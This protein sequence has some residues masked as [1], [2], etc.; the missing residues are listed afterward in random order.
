MVARRLRS[1]ATCSGFPRRTFMIAR[2]KSAAGCL[3]S[4]LR[5]APNSR[6]ASSMFPVSARATA[7]SDRS[8]WSVETLDLD[9]LTAVDLNLTTAAD[10][11]THGSMQMQDA[12]ADL[13]LHDGRLTYTLK[14]IGIDKGRATG[15]MDVDASAKPAKSARVWIFTAPRCWQILPGSAGRRCRAPARWRTRAETP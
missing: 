15:R 3:G 6:S 14:Q 4:S 9:A 8:S 1:S 12:R 10:L 2:L 11:I 5:I 7:R 13:L